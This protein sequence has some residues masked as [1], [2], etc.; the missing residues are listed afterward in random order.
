[1]AANYSQLETMMQKRYNCTSLEIA[2]KIYKG[3][4][5]IHGVIKASADVDGWKAFFDNHEGLKRT[6]EGE[7]F[8]GR[9]GKA[10]AMDFLKRVVANWM[11]QDLFV[12]N[13]NKNKIRCELGKAHKGRSFDGC[14]SV[15]PTAI[16]WKEVNG[17][18]RHRLLDI[19]IVY[20]KSMEDGF[21]TLTKE[22]YLKLI[23][24]KAVLLTMNMTTLKYS[25]LDF[26][27]TDTY[28]EEFSMKNGV[29][30]VK[31]SLKESKGEV[32]GLSEVRNHLKRVM[33]ETVGE[34]AVK[35]SV[36]QANF[37]AVMELTLDGIGKNLVG[38]YTIP[39]DA[40]EKRKKTK[41]N[42]EGMNGESG[43]VGESVKADAVEKAVEEVENEKPKP[44][45]QSAANN[46]TQPYDTT[47]EKVKANATVEAVKKP[48]TSA[49]ASVQPKAQVTQTA[50]SVS[51]NTVTGGQSVKA[52]KETPTQSSVQKQTQKPILQTQKPIQK[53]MQKQEARQA[54][55]VEEEDYG[56]YDFSALDAFA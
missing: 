28:A 30:V 31:V 21:V 43:K 24:K 20:G 38:A 48:T 51:T 49:S 10:G 2:E 32:K 3:R 6:L 8:K 19:Q 11:A 52:A 14:L 33:E 13:L 45:T 29:C 37:I 40:V 1:M 18:E 4:E 54:T 35:P 36:E 42:A 15:E 26:Y 46:A 25:L 41:G 22:R 16:L 27:T 44:S 47:K 12:M 50:K 7:A 56:G 9:I 23:E 53:P 34:K 39:K 17:K 55:Q 5:D